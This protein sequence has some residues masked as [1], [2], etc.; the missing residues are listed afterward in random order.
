MRAF[1]P[2]LLVLALGACG[3]NPLNNTGTGSSGSGSSGSGS[4]SGSGTSGGITGSTALPPGGVPTGGCNT[5]VVRYEASDAST[6]AGY[7]TN[8]NY[9]GPTT[10]TF[11]V[12]NL[13]FVGNNVFT[14]DPVLSGLGSN[15]P[16]GVYESAATYT[17]SVTGAPINQ[18]TYR[19]IY[20]TSPSGKTQF[21][22][23]R[24]GD[25]VNYG[26]GGFIYQR[27]GTVTLPT[28]GQASYA[29]DYA[30]LVDY[31][32]TSGINYTTGAMTMAIDFNAFNTSQTGAAA[33]AVYGYVTNRKVFD[34]NGNDVTQTVLDALNTAKNTT[35][36][37]LPNLIFTVAP[38]VMT[39]NGEIAGQV[40]SSVPSGGSSA[41][42]ESGT[43]YAV[44]AD[45]P[46][47]NVG[48]VVGIITVTSTYPGASLTARET[49]GFIL[50]RQ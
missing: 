37:A 50:A 31:N 48:E 42:Y 14:R 43:Y 47:H 24:T 36:T 22:I 49:G 13:P 35:L 16:Y 38:G 39:S 23:V 30:G 8:I 25:F 1:F 33:N 4:S 6:G 18:F 15:S 27:N 12:Q 28:S 32:G 19:A 5:C 34:T 29:G 11:T 46:T 17:D 40:G 45:N 20:A 26:F 44:L 21:A 41:A 2:A 7:A 3:G 10:D 9:S